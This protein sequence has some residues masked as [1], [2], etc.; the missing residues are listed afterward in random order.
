M[1]LSRRTRHILAWTGVTVGVLVGAVLLALVL[2]DWNAMKGPIER[3][4][5]ARSGRTVKIAGDIE[6][7]PWSWTPSF[8]VSGLTV[9]NPPWEAARPMAQIER[10]QVQIKLLPLLKGDVILPRVEIIRPQVYLHREASG[11]ANWTFENTTPTNEK[12]GPPPNL[13][14]VRDFVIDGGKLTVNDELLKLTVDGTIVAR[15]KASES[16]PEAFKI[17]G[18]GKINQQPFAAN[19]A[20]GPLI[21]LQPDQPYPF[22][23]AIEAGDIRVGAK[24][25]VKKPFDLARV[26]LA[27][28]ASGG[29]LADLY[30]LTHLAM[31]NTPPFKLAANI[32]RDV[33]KIHVT[34]LKGEVGQSDLSGALLID[35]SRKRPSITGQ[36]KSDRLRLADLAAPL[37]GKPKTAGTL[38]AQTEKAKPSKKGAEEAAPANAKLFPTARLQVARVRA[39]DGDVKFSAHSIEAGSLPLKEVAFEVKLDDGV[40]SLA[41]FAFEMPQGKL[42]GTVHIDARGDKPKTRL[43]VRVK[44]VQLDQLKGKAPDA[45][46]PLG[47]IVQ[48]RAT[49]EG[50]GDS[51]HDFMA[52]AN[53]RVSAVVPRGQVNAAFAE[54]TGINVARGIGLLI[55]GNDERAEIR[56]GVAQFDVKQGTMQAANVVFDTT[57]VKITGQGEV[58]LGPEE[59][60]LSIKGQPKKLRFARLRTPVEINGHLRKPSIGIDA[61]DTVKQGAVAAALGAALTPVA[62]LLAFID[63][64][65]AKDENCAAL[66][67]SAKTPATKTASKEE[68][69]PPVRR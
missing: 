9:G 57:N 69:K 39:M 47:G 11:R 22:D 25:Q 14:V 66:L 8:A 51:V 67:E 45:K 55:T 7:H 33:S 52:D 43:D 4:A 63:P 18:K 58:R 24:G 68:P 62:A 27:A 48:A 65:L 31:P 40:L 54:L 5:S 35:V 19:I 30:H 50:T 61:G 16:D 59:L 53:G 34:G 1:N 36:L 49:F 12:E 2:I 26:S 60:D 46:P 41:P 44:D 28:S 23:L 6:V 21:N 56:C 42:S 17:Q 64:G 37:G 29:D 10:I 20:G 13:P 38:S 15:E 32:V 3:M